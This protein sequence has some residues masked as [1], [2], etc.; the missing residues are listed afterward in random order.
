MT[1]FKDYNQLKRL[2]E[3]A[4]LINTTFNVNIED[5]HINLYGMKEI[6][7]RYRGPA[8]LRIGKTRSSSLQ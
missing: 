4:T 2:I 6:F 5:N 8:F 1:S 7:P 3:A